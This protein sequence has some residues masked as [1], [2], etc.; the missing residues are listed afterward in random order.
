MKWK[1][2]VYFIEW[3]RWIDQQEIEEIQ[4]T[5]FSFLVRWEG[6]VTLMADVSHR[7]RFHEHPGIPYEEVHEVFKFVNKAKKDLQIA[8]TPC[9]G[10]SEFYVYDSYLS[11]ENHK[12]L[13]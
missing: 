3:D 9:L 6:Q 5:R 13:S 11:M 8:L 12:P 2:A 7:S 1:D 4:D 10:H